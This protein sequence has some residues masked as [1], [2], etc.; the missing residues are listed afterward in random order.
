MRGRDAS[1]IK[2][3]RL[4]SSDQFSISGQSRYRCQQ[5]ESIFSNILFSLRSFC[6]KSTKL[7]LGKSNL[8]VIGSCFGQ[9]QKF[10]WHVGGPAVRHIRF[11]MIPVQVH[12]IFCV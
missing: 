4:D 3:I 10:G 6:E 12:R 11:A 7:N 8:L 1:P 9:L 5:N 2:T